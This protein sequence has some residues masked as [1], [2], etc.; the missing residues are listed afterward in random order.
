MED[1]LLEMGFQNRGRHYEKED[2]SPGI[3]E[4]SHIVPILLGT[5]EA[6]LLVQHSEKTELKSPCLKLASS[7]VSSLATSESQDQHNVKILGTLS[8]HITHVKMVTVGYSFHSRGSLSTGPCWPHRGHAHKAGPNGSGSSK[9][10]S[11]GIKLV[12]NTASPWFLVSSLLS[13]SLHPTN[14]ISTSW[15]D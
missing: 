15:L 9:D 5:P 2:S 12:R 11:K 3:R 10:L 14:S 7:S 8:E 13:S 4:A 1:T 6:L